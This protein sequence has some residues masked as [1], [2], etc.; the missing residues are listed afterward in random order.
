MVGS[1]VCAQDMTVDDNGLTV[2]GNVEIKSGGIVFPDGTVLDNAYLNNNNGNSPRQPFQALQ[3]QIDE[4]RQQ[5]EQT[6]EK[7][8]EVEFYQP[9]LELTTDNA[10]MVA[11]TGYFEY[12]RDKHKYK[13][14]WRKVKVDPNL[15]I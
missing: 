4:L 11:I 2:E 3:E 5:L 6:V 10:L 9:D 15:E 12:I 8:E 13:N 14:Y 1:N 7:L